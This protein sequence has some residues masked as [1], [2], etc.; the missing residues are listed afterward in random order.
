MKFAKD[1]LWHVYMCEGLKRYEICEIFFMKFMKDIFEKGYFSC[2]LCLIIGM[3]L[4]NESKLTVLFIV[5][6]KLLLFVLNYYKLLLCITN[7]F[8]ASRNSLLTN[9]S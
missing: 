5:Y 9:V 2:L 8:N 7:A 3:F 4:R 1:S 6:Y